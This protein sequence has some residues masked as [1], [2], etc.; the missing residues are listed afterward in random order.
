[1]AA[2]IRVGDRRRPGLWT[3]RHHRLGNEAEARSLY[4]RARDGMPHALLVAGDLDAADEL[5]WFE[6]EAAALFD[7]RDNGR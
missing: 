1:M 7:S 4:E 5:L 6:A 3:R 2:V